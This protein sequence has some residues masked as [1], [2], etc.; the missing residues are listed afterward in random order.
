MIPRGFPASK[1]EG[2]W[3]EGGKRKELLTRHC[4]IIQLYLLV[5]FKKIKFDF[6]L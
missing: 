4:K 1:G 6:R 5:K 3:R 2:V